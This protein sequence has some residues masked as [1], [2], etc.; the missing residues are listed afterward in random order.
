MNAPAPDAEMVSGAVFLGEWRR[1]EW[2]RGRQDKGTGLAVGWVD[3]G[4][5]L[6]R[7]P[8]KIFGLQ[9]TGTNL[10]AALLERNFR[11]LSL[12]PRTEWKHGPVGKVQRTWQG[13]AVRYV[14]CVRNPYAWLVACYRYFQKVKG[15]DRS[16]A[17]QFERNASMSFDEFVMTPSYGFDSP[18]ARW[19]QMNL[20]WLSELPPKYTAVV[21]QEDQ[22]TGQVAVLKRIERRFGFSRKSDGLK[23]IRAHGCDGECA[24]RRR[25]C[26]GGVANLHGELFAFAA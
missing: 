19:N 11:V 16:I 21:R 9:R 6:K 17:P 5:G 13:Q 8:Y 25:R 23:G 22:L 1:R 14:V 10:M 24:A 20:H 18:V 2:G 4:R 15:L 12:E 26:G 7:V 3:M